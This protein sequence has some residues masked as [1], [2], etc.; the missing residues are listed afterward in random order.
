MKKNAE[1]QFPFLHTIFLKLVLSTV[2]PPHDLWFCSFDSFD[3]L[4][5]CQGVHAL[6]FCLGNF[7]Q[8]EQV[9]TTMSHLGRFSF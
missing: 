3:S 2:R 5:S 7:P 8:L 6:T 4:L 1:C 9:S